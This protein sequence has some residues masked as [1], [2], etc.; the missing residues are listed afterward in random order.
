MIAQ[1]LE[2]KH[3]RSKLVHYVV[4]HTVSAGDARRVGS[5]YLVNKFVVEDF[6]VADETRRFLHMVSF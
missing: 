1:A 3:S 5:A 6:G 4:A 2:I